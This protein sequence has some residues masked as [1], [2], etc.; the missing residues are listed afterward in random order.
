MHLQRSADRHVIKI[1]PF[2]H[3]SCFLVYFFI[4]T[5]A[6]ALTIAREETKKLIQLVRNNLCT[7]RLAKKHKDVEC[8]IHGC[9]RS[10]HAS[11]SEHHGLAFTA[12]SAMVGNAHTRVASAVVGKAHT[13][14]AS[15]KVGK[16]H[17]RVASAVVGK[18]HTTVA[19]A[20]GGKA[21][22]RVAS[23]VAGKAHTRV[24]V[25]LVAEA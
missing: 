23:A 14:V 5:Q 21:H 1:E 8:V 18:A 24:A 3:F 10:K 13:S 6:C 12:A 22:A 9:R 16:A 17:T 7:I 15:P 19:S 11:D 25:T 20:V 2:H 4:M